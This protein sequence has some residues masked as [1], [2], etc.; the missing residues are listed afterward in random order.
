MDQVTSVEIVPK[1]PANYSGKSIGGNINQVTS[2]EIL[3]KIWPNTSGES[4][5][6]LNPRAGHAQYT[7][8]KYG[9]WIL[10]LLETWQSRHL[11]IVLHMAWQSRRQ[12]TKSNDHISRNIVAYVMNAG[13]H[14][15][16]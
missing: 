4:L 9:H 3:P 15:C 2:I 7:F 6:V 11:G 8:L 12:C 10:W 1:T 5:E 16:M 14:V 13:M